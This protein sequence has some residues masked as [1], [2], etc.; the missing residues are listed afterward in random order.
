MRIW[1]SLGSV[2]TA[3]PLVVIAMVSFLLLLKFFQ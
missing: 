1:V 3:V 2:T